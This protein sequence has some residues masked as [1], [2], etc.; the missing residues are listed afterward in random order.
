MRSEPERP[1]L[2]L[3]VCCG[4]CATAVAERLRGDFRVEAVWYNP[5]IQPAAEHE[6]RLAAMRR[7]AEAMDLPLTV[8]DYDVPRWEAACA[9]LMDEPEGGARCGVCFRLRLMRVAQ[10]AAERGMSH[11]ATTLTVS[12]HKPAAR[13][14]ALGL[15][16]AAECGIHFVDEDFRQRDGFARSVQLSRELGLYRQR[17]CG[18]LPS[19]RTGEASGHE[20]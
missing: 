16:T 1:R 14:N 11:L 12:P 2:A 19:I 17:Y 18:C 9:G 20:D 13:I 3:H 6:R 5:N 8:L 15:Q 10:F 7:V 4:P